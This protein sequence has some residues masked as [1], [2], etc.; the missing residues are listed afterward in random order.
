MHKVK[1][2]RV[3]EKLMREGLKEALG[4]QINLSRRLYE[5]N[6]ISPVQIRDNY[7]K[8]RVAAI[9]CGVDTSAWDS[10]Y[11]KSKRGG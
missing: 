3:D 7:Q 6:R 10:L 8:V 11:A 5:A 9:V 4:Y 1:Q 2:L